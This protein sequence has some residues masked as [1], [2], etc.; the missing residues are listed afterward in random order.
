MRNRPRKSGLNRSS[1]AI[2]QKKE[3]LAI[4]ARKAERRLINKRQN[5]RP[6]SRPTDEAMIEYILKNREL[7]EKHYD[8]VDAKLKKLGYVEPSDGA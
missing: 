7:F 4:K 3:R 8:D 6:D 2:R 5:P 1:V